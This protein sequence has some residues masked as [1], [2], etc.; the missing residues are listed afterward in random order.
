MQPTTIDEYISSPELKYAI[1]GK[2]EYELDSVAQS[3]TPSPR[4]FTLNGVD[5]VVISVSRFG[6]RKFYDY[7]LSLGIGVDFG[8]QQHTGNVK[9]MLHGDMVAFMSQF[10]ESQEAV[11]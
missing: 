2:T 11:V 9:L 3:I 1:L 10:N 6:A 7:V 8:M 5:Y 4:G